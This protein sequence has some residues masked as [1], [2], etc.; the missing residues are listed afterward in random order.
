MEKIT[1]IPKKLKGLVKIPP[2]K[3]L[4]HRG[5]ICA[6]LSKGISTIENIDFSDDIIATI[7]AME[8]LGTEITC[9]N[10]K[11]IVNGKNTFAKT[12]GII[13]CNESGSTL[14]FLVPLSIVKYNK[15]KFVGKGN[16][17]KRPLTTYF[18]IF[19]RQD[20]N[21]ELKD[22]LL[23]LEIL[24]KLK[25]GEFKIPGNISSQFISGL[26]FSL[27]ILDEDSKIIISTPLE[28]K[29]Y[30][31]LTIDTMQK[32]GVTI[33]NHNYKEFTIDGRQN[34][35][36]TNYKVEGDYSQAAFYFSANHLGNNVIL[37]DLNS[38][39]LQGDKVCVDILEKIS[40]T[41]TDTIIIDA[42]QCP[43]IIPIISVTASLRKGTTKI[44]NGERLRIKECDRLSAICTELKKLGA[45]IEEQKNGLIIK[46][47]KSLTGGIVH[48]HN[49]HRI[50]MSMAIASTR[51]INNL[52]LESPNC[53]S[54]SYPKF[55]D[56]FKKLGGEIK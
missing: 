4:G 15:I 53:T 46:G 10:N 18:D 22:G 27:P 34:Y 50:A 35:K 6:S 56:D 43:D 21:Y 49:D 5:I 33:K 8:T 45:N 30:V 28:S 11:L 38:N 9:E 2:S 3:S 25:G 12:G 51:C 1:I 7:K 54:K 39:S 36:A 19:S 23:D 31:D 13:D 20:I 24:G 17:G 32:F 55:W 40:T 47:I 52:I 37:E 16:L 29:S 44:I 42:S 48:S 14:R 41:R 26:L